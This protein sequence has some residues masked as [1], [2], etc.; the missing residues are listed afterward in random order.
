MHAPTQRLTQT[1]IH[2]PTDRPALDR[3]ALSFL[4]FYCTGHM[5]MQKVGGRVWL[6]IHIYYECI[7]IVCVSVSMYHTNLK[8]SDARDRHGLNPSTNT[9]HHTPQQK[10]TELEEELALLRHEKEGLEASLRDEV[11]AKVK[12]DLSLF[13]H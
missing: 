10:N 4:F 1:S 8:S 11:W 3:I 9:H 2:K 12:Y 5:F 7:F 13:V 6:C